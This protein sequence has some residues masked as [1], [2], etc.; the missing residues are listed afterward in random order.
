VHRLRPLSQT[1]VSAELG[2]ALE[3][4]VRDQLRS[5]VAT[6]APVREAGAT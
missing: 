6:M 4:R 2:R 1:V 5:R 3:R